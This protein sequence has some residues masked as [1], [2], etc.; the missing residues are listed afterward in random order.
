MWVL[1]PAATGWAA[2]G[3]GSS[4]RAPAELAALGAVNA[5]DAARTLVGHQRDAGV[6]EIESLRH[7]GLGSTSG[8][9]LDG[10]DAQFGHLDRILL[11]GG[12]D[13]T[14]LDL[15]Y[16]VAATVD[17]DDQDVLEPG[18]L[19]GLLGADGGRLVDGVN[20]VDL[21][22]LGEAPFHGRAPAVLRAVG[23]L[24]TD[25]LVRPAGV[26]AGRGLVAVLRLVDGVDP[27]PGQEA[28]VAVVVHRDDLVVEKVEHGD[29]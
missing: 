3:R 4:D 11:G 29:G 24:V 19:Q 8:D 27:H 6:E 7:R 17:G 9:L 20:D 5:G 13:D 23:G 21:L 25:D 1:D 15:L 14:V 26:V 28:L 12:A 16:A 22:V 2:T 10:L 18:R